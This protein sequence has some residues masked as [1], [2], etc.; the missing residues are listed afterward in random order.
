MDYD[1]YSDEVSEG[2]EDYINE[3][4]RKSNPRFEVSK[5]LT[6]LCSCSG[7]LQ[8]VELGSN[9]TDY[10]AEAISEPSV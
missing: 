2:N 4:Q 1:S 8:K 7:V 10:L 9:E 5:N 6:E 3:N